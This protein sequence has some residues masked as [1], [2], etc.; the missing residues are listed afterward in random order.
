MRLQM[1]IAMLLA[2]ASGFG[3]VDRFSQIWG[4]KDG[5]AVDL[6]GVVTH[7][8]PDPADGF[9]MANNVRHDMGGVRVLPPGGTEEIDGAYALAAGET[10]VVRGAI[11]RDGQGMAI[12]SQ[13]VMRTGRMNLS[14]PPDL[15]FSDFRKGMLGLRRV[16]VEGWVVSCTDEPLAGGDVNSVVWMRLPGTRP[17]L[18]LI[19]RGGLGEPSLSRLGAHIAVHGIVVNETDADGRFIAAHV[20]ANAEDVRLV[21]AV[22]ADWW[23]IATVAVGSL[24]GA[25]LI[26]IIA[27]RLHILR[28]RRAKALVADVRRNIADDL[29]DNMQ[30][31]LAGMA[32]RLDAAKSV[33]G[34]SKAVLEQIAK[35]EKALEHSQAGLRSVLWGLQGE[36]GSADS[37]LGLFRYAAQRMPHWQGVVEISGEGVEDPRLNKIGGR[38]LMILQEAVGNALKHGGARK[39]DVS[40]AKSAGGFTMT[41][42]DD[43]CGFDTSAAI[44]SGHMGLASIRRRAREIGGTLTITSEPGKGTEIRIEVGR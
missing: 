2:A 17:P 26:V 5:E 23:R 11:A 21:R 34:G 30:Q 32:F 15:K 22:P 6:F 37:L 28:E 18:P 40:L 14:E 1:F 44:P 29:H 39:I 24:L 3:A 7:V 41:I 4:A 13:R 19:V 12:R 36:G 9:V 20:E 43:G 38:L 8:F 16:R 31:L 35:A 33:A 10:V 27:M 42:R 25:L